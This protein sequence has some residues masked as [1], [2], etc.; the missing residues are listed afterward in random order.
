MI[1]KSMDDFVSICENKDFRRVYAKGKSYVDPVLVVYVLKNRTKNVRI[2]ITTS[3][4]TGNAVKRNRS[5]RI[6][7]AAY[8][9]IA[10]QIKAGYDIIFVARAR[11]PFV[12]STDILKSMSVLLKN[13]GVLK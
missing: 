3:K 11:T 1:L 2:G 5:R 12:K 13:S 10:P 6:I 7:R 8:R 9:E 4:K